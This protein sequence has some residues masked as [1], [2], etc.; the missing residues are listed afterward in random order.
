MCR[1]RHWGPTGRGAEGEPTDGGPAGA[2]W[3]AVDT[4]QLGNN[5]PTQASSGCSCDGRD[6]CTEEP[7]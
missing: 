5:Q 6:L 3:E 2:E 1:V 4:G 7:C